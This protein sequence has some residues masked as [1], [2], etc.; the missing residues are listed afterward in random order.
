MTTQTLRLLD[1]YGDDI[2]RTSIDVLLDKQLHDPGALALL[3]EQ[4][5][6][7]TRRDPVLEPSFGDH[8]KDRDVI[9]HSLESYDH[10]RRR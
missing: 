8:V 2:F 7:K 4:A 1:L 10:R 9:P 6:S 3:C 5:R